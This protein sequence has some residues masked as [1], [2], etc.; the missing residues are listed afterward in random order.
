MANI[1][2]ITTFFE[3]LQNLNAEDI[4]SELDDNKEAIRKR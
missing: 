2:K 4:I 1:D 3:I